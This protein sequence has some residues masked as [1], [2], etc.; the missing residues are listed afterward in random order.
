MSHSISKSLSIGLL[1][2]FL[3]ACSSNNQKETKSFSEKA[4]LESGIQNE[5]IQSDQGFS[6]DFKKSKAEE[7]VQQKKLIK[8]G[9]LTLKSKH[10]EQSKANLDKILEQVGGYYDN[11]SFSKSNYELRYSL[12]LRIP[13]AKFDQLLQNINTGSDEILAKNIH[14][15]DVGEEYYDIETR[16]KSKK[17]YLK[18]YQE[19]M[20]NAK[21]VDDLLQIESQVRQLIEE[22][23]SQE[24]RLRFLDN[25]VGYGTLN[26]ELFKTLSHPPI[27]PDENSFWQDAG[28]SFSYG[29]STIVGCVLWLLSI[30]PLLLIVIPASIFGYRKFK[31]KRNKKLPAH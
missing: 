18:R 22:I 26:I 20:S 28:N 25:Q 5:E 30:W 7:E 17:A 15:E 14:A 27:V 31:T 1:P 23:E 8:T 6:A 12:Q 3:V 13:S 24:G 2:F 21:N 19:I 11:E 29:W 16:L 4:I 9:E 10:I